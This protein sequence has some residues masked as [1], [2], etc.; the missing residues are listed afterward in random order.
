MDVQLEF[1]L[2]VEEIQRDLDRRRPG[3]NRF[4]SARSVRSG[5]I[6]SGI[7]EGKIVSATPIML[8]VEIIKM[9]AVRTI[10]NRGDLSA[11]PRDFSYTA[12]IR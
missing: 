6:L 8:V 12:R 4:S 10:G 7:F 11:K 2:S 3:Q 1:L 9:R 5:P